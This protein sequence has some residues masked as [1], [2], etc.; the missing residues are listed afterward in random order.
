MGRWVILAL[1]ILTAHG[2]M[3]QADS[4]ERSVSPDSVSG[5]VRPVDA[6]HAEPRLRHD[7]FFDDHNSTRIEPA[8]VPPQL[9]KTL[10]DGRYE[11]WESGTLMR[12]I[13]TGEYRLE[14]IRGKDKQTHIFNHLGERV[15]PDTQ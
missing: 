1:T 5:A 9:R 11:G 10:Q 7:E 15:G 8:Q 2:V 13:S 12:N 6:D 3:G 14:F 4:V